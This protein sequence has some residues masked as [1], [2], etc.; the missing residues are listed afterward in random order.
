MDKKQPKHWIGPE[1]LNPGYWSDKA[2]Q[3]KRGQEFFEKPVEWIE[4]M[5]N[6]PEGGFARRDFLTVMGASMAMATFACARRPVH[7][8]IPYVV[9]PEELTPGV[10]LFYAS[11]SKDCP[12]GCGVLVK[13]REGR[14][15]KLEGNPD[16]PLNGGALCA[17][18]QASVL[19]LYDP[20]RLASPVARG[21]GGAGSGRKEVSWSEADGA[22]QARLRS[23]ASGGGKVRVLSQ[24]VTSSAT[25]RLIREFTGAF[26]AGAHIQYNPLAHEEL[27]EGQRE[28]YG[29]ALYPTY[30]FDRA[31]L[32]V[33]VGADFLGTW[34]SPVEHAAD[35]ARSRKLDSSK[36]A[37]SKMSKLV[38]YESSLSLTGSNA[39]E[40]YPIRPGDELDVVMAILH[41]LVIKQGRSSYGEGQLKD[42]LGSYDIGTLGTAGVVSPAQI[43]GLAK[44]LWENRGKSIVVAG[45]LRTTTANAMQLQ[46]AVN[47]LNTI[48]ENDGATI[49]GAVQTAPARSRFGEVSKLVADMKAGNVEVLV[50]YRSNPV[51]HLPKV[52]EFEE[53]LKKVPFVIAISDREDE[54]AL[55]ADYVLPDHHFLENW[56]D[57]NP[58]K[59]LYSLQQPTIAPIHQTRAFEDSLITWIKGANLR[60]S[61]ATK[62]NDWHQ[63][64]RDHWKETFY[65]GAGTFDEFWD[66]VLRSGVFTTSEGVGSSHARSFNTSALSQLQKRGQKAVGDTG[67][68]LV[69]YASTNL[70]DGTQANNP[71]LQELPDPISSVVWDNYLAVGP[72]MAKSLSL[73]QDDVVTVTGDG[74]S[75]ELPV[76]VQPGMHPNAVAAAVGYGRSAAGRVGDGAG[77]NLFSI[78]KVFN[79]RPVYSGFPVTIKKTQKFYRLAT[80]Q[81]HT[82]SENRPILN[83]IPLALYKKNPGASAEVDPELRMEKVPSIWPVHEY[84]GHRWGM[85]IDLNACNGCSA[86]MIACQAEN[87]IPVVGRDQVRMGRNMHWIRIDRYFSGEANDPNVIFQPM[88]CQHCENA[89]CETV[90]PVLATVHDDEGVNVQIYNRCVGTRYCQNNC[91]YK[92]R[93]FNFFDHWKSYEG[94]MNLAWNPDVT[95][96]TRGIM[97]KCTFCVQ[98]VVAA[99]DKAKDTGL[100][101]RDGEF[102]VACQQTCPTEAI[103]FGDMN[104]P[105]SRV[106]RLKEDARAF[107]ALETLNT[108]PSVTYMTKV[109]NAAEKEERT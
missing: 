30:H 1:E 33:S 11:T 58:R 60:G 65:K 16:H 67:A 77:V 80:T 29:A 45:G 107:H 92:V 48:L 13:T 40:R 31:E 81:W 68:A 14:P 88:L 42:V 25:D 102:Q 47:L 52:M 15:I 10:P 8:I 59:G 108:K 109:R 76:Y 21:R 61:L 89:P 72:E 6:S 63:Y 100:P 17:Q 90:C 97:E 105:H 99:K 64:L 83:D 104:D 94:T 27:A 73:S 91:P 103:V 101:L 74:F 7:K 34:L 55:L 3:E 98:R 38:C 69:L 9:Q 95:V 70:G 41:E 51:Y 2:V 87:N 46:V 66:G 43:K 26:S 86:C 57:A 49:D 5:D 93:R 37:Q 75:F 18:A 36:A 56:G 22:I 84:K 96:R 71:W 4:R 79:S 82:A 62:A 28:C 23:A 53:A 35:F 19:S 20:G 44:E 24:V 12:C 78:A 32:V 50:L 39:D 85:T 54:T 106:S